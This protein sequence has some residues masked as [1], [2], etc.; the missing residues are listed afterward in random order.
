MYV[1]F[2]GGDIS[3]WLWRCVDRRRDAFSRASEILAEAEWVR[4]RGTC[5]SL[6]FLFY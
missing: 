4:D 6:E 3:P 1:L 2:F 5:K